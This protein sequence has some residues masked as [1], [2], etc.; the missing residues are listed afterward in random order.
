[1][2]VS[3]ENEESLSIVFKAKER[4]KMAPSQAVRNV[5]CEFEDGVLFLRGQVS[6]FFEKQ[7]AQEAVFD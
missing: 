6:S 2:S 3:V 1:M 4:L 7:L 5:S